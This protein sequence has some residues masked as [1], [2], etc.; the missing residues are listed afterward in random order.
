[1]K[2]LRLVYLLAI[3]LMVFAS[4]CN[5][6]D[7]EPAPPP[8]IGTWLLDRYQISD[9]PAPYNELNGIGYDFYILSGVGS[10]L[11]I[12]NNG[13]FSEVR[14]FNGYVFDLN[15]TWEF[16]NN[17]LNLNYEDEDQDNVSLTYEAT[18][19]RLLGEKYPFRDTIDSVEVNF[20]VQEVYIKD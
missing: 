12:N 20:N 13:N 14:K 16:T 8:V 18:I 11:T 3:S 5:K 15:G 10:R 2:K 4:A 17:Q 19:D 1:M 6:D 9:A 7:D